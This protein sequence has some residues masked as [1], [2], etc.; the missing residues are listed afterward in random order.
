MKILIIHN[1]Y[2]P[3]YRGGAEIVALNLVEGIKNKGDEP[4]VVALDYQDKIEEIDNVKVYRLKPF[5]IFNYIDINKKSFFLRCIFHLID[6]FNDVTPW[7]V[8]KIAQ[9]EKPDFIFLQGIK[10]FGYI[11]PRLLKF[12]KF[13]TV[14]RVFDMQFIHPS[15]LLLNNKKTLLIRFYVFFTKLLLDNPDIV[16]FPSNYVKEVYQSSSLFNA[17]EIKIINNPLLNK[18]IV[19]VNKIKNEEKKGFDFLFLGQVEKYKGLDDLIDALKQVNG[20]FTLHVVG[21]GNYLNEL[22]RKNLNNKKIIFYGQMNKDRLN[23]EIW[24]KI[25]LLINPSRV[26]ETFGM[27]IIEAYARGVPVIAS[28][29]GALKEIVKENKTGWL[30]R[31]G[32]VCHLKYKLQEIL[33]GKIKLIDFNEDCLDEAKNFSIDNYLIKLYESIFSKK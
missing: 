31:S 28:E 32:D 29:I 10:G 8:L 33:D 26:G 2:K 30:F 9:E 12:Y 3:Y 27:V 7:K 23:E 25:D 19:Q 5:N 22:K 21:E 14:L 4:I 1:I 17:S 16:I 11:L 24:P 18:D 20:D 6:I 13:K 15:G